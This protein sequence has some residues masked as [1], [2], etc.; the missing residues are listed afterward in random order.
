[1][2]T[3]QRRLRFDGSKCISCRACQFVCSQQLGTSSFLFSGIKVPAPY[4]STEATFCKQCREPSCMES[5][6]LNAIYQR[7]GVVLID[8]NS[9]EGCGLCV[10]AC[11]YHAMFWSEELRKPFKCTLCNGGEPKCV[12][13]CPTGAL[14][15]EEA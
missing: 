7:G 10:K 3:F 14:G 15:V 5:C 12:Q 9:C 4:E 8:Y 6:D 11:P 13:V 1:M 2:I